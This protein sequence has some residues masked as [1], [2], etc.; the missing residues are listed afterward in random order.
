MKNLI[1]AVSGI[2]LIISF[3]AIIGVA[4]GLEQDL[5]TMSEAIK[6][7]SICLICLI[8]SAIGIKYAIDE[9]GT[10]MTRF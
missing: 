10:E 5:L 6:W 8:L 9:D 4:G 2:M 3:I 7:G 1:S